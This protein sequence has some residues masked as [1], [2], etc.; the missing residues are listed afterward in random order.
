MALRRVGNAIAQWFFRDT[1]Q[2]RG[3]FTGANGSVGTILFKGLATISRSGE[4]VYVLTVLAADGTSGLKGYHIKALDF[5][6]VAPAAAD[7]GSGP[8]PEITTDALNSAGTITFTTRNLAG[9]AADVIGVC[10]VDLEISPEAA[11]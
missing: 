7:G 5:T 10:F 6:F 11:S 3:K 9:T 2:V 1:Q 8:K 4:G